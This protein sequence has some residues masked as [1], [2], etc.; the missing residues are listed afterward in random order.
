MA[1]AK[2]TKKTSTELFQEAISAR[3][4]EAV[5]QPVTARS[6]FELEQ[7][8]RLARQF[9]AVSRDPRALACPGP[10][11]DSTVVN[12]VFNSPYP[13]SFGVQGIAVPTVA[14]GFGALAPAPP[15]ENF[16]ATIV[17]EMME[18]S[19]RGLGDAGTL[20]DA[21]KLARDKGLVALAEQF[22]A[23]LLAEL[24]AHVDEEK[25]APALP[26]AAPTTETSNAASPLALP[27]PTTP[28]PI[29]NGALA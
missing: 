1:K 9:F 3:L 5:N 28:A 6:L 26:A 11:G 13:T 27:P 18:R 10:D 17:R 12:P 7:F 20:M 19:S 29:T 22:E 23:K 24:T 25:P 4:D 2:A 15:A 21:A 16:G 8:I 14:G